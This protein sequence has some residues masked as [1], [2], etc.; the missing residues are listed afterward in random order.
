[1]INEKMMECIYTLVKCLSFND[2][3]LS[4]G[5]QRGSASAKDLPMRKEAH[6]L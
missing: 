3:I 4:A 2:V 5:M 6:D 1:M